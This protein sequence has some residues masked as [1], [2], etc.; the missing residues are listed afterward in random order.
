MS[1]HVVIFTGVG[2]VRNTMRAIGAYRIASELRSAGYRVKVLDYTVQLSMLY[3]DRWLGLVDKYVSEDTLWVGFSSTFLI[4]PHSQRRLTSGSFPT[5]IGLPFSAELKGRFLELIKRKNPNVQVVVGGA[6][7]NRKIATNVDVFI[8][9]YADTSAIQYTR[10]LQG[11]LSSVQYVVNPQKTLSVAYDRTAAGFDFQHSRTFWQDDDV[12]LPN[13]ALPIEIARGCI[14]RC[15]FCAYPLNGK[16]K[17]D[18]IRDHGKLR[19]ELIEQYER[20][21]TTTYMLSDDTFNDSMDK[22]EGLWDQVISKLP[23]RFRFA[24]YLR[25]DLLNAHPEQIQLLRSLGIVGAHFGVE[26]LNPKTASAVGKGLLPERTLNTIQRCKEEWTK[27]DNQCFLCCSFIIGLPH[28][29]R[30]TITGWMEQALNQEYLDRITLHPLTMSSSVTPIWK[31]K[32]EREPVKYGYDIQVNGDWVNHDTGMTSDIAH[33]MT[34]H[35]LRETQRRNRFGPYAFDVPNLL[36]A[37][38]TLEQLQGR[39]MTDPLFQDRGERARRVYLRYLS[40]L[41]AA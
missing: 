36:N 16:K 2:E 37:G 21:G 31:S 34:R 3:P 32:M 19:E 40:T 41:E 13:E 18:Y 17:N 4:N 33:D 35:Y 25:A 10:S 28:D 20:F 8:E 23:F 15:A 27:D 24:S 38:Y 5:S 30:E 11:K 26:S 1:Y 9:G 14:F 7:A 12:M 22:L 6:N 29:T 39:Q